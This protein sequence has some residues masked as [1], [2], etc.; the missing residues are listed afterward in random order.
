MSFLLPH[1]R[2]GSGR[3]LGQVERD[4]TDFIK[5]STSVAYICLFNLVYMYMIYVYVLMI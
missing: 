2:C 4:G 5:M 1:I 3:F